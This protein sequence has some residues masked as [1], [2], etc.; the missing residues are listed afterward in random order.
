MPAPHPLLAAAARLSRA[1]SPLRFAPPVTHVYDPLVYA[2]PL[3]QA[4]VRRF[5]GPGKRVVFLGMNPGPYGM[6]QTGV[7][8][9]E[10]AA[11]RD[12][13]G[14]SGRVGVPAREHPKRPI[15]GLAC[16]R[17]EVSGRRLWGLFQ[18]RFGSPERFFARHFVANYCP[19]VFM[20][21]SGRNRTPNQLPKDEAAAV[22]AAC[23]RHLLQ[24][25]A[26]LAPEIV[27]GVGTYAAGC[28][29]RVLQ[30]V[31]VRIATIP[32]PSP[33]NPSANKDWIGLTERALI[34]QGVWETRAP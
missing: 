26:A 28:A 11:V 25:V 32:H 6:A 5:G 2:W 16:A 17:S 1:L 30:G 22:A 12:W 29:E 3:H 21:G 27:V 18:S 23:D 34:R 20:E 9:G 7:P 24:L 33:A 14:L 8:F 15:Q 10:V 19:L 13:M 4:Y 31:P